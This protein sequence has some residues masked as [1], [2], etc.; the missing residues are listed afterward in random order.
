VLLTFFLVIDRIYN[1]TDLVIT[2]GVPFYLVVQLLAFMLPS[3]LAI[4]LPMAFLSA[5]LLAG[6]R[7]A[8]DLEI[9]AFRAAGV[10][11]LRLFRPVLLASLVIMAATAWFTLV[12]NPLANREFQRQLFRILQAKAAS[13]LQ[14]RI[15]LGTFGDVTIYVEDVSVSQVALR[16]LL[17]SDERDPKMSRII[18]ARE[19]RLRSDE[20]NQRITLSMIDGAV[21]EVDVT[22]GAAQ[23]TTA[24]PLRPAVAPRYRHTRFET[25]DMSLAMS[26]PLIGAAR[27]DKPERDA[28]LGEL[29]QKI[30]E[31]GHQ[32]VNRLPYEIERHKRFALPAAALVFGLIAFPLAIRS[33][34]GGRSIAFIGSL[35]ILVIYYLLITSLEGFAL[36]GRIP[37]AVAIWTPNVLFTGAGFGL[38]VATAREWRWPAVP[39]LWRGLERVRRALPS[40][41]ASRVRVHAAGAGRDSTHIIDRYLVREY[42]AFMG[43]GLAVSAALFVMIDLL[44]TLDRYLR[45]KPPLVFIIEHFVYRLPA[46][47]HLYLPVVMLVATIFLFLTLGRYHELTALKAAGVS[48]YRVSMPIL[49]LGLAIAIGAGVFQE[50]ALP[51]LNE[52]GDE[53]DRVKIRGMA[54]RHLQLRHRLW[55][56]SSDSRFYRVELLHPGTNDMFGVTILELN[57]DFRLTG[58]LDARQAHWTPAGWELRDGAYREIS[59]DGA[60]Q[61]LPFRS[62]AVELSEEM[63]DF[64]RI[65]KPVTAMSF[66][67]LKDYIARLEAAGFQIRKHLVEL[68]A[69]L[70]FPLVNLV[71]VLVAIPLALQSPRGGRL[72]GIGLA[73]G[74]MAGYLVV[75]FVALAFARADLL[76]PLI[77]AWTANIIFMGIGVSLLLRA[78]T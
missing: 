41:A 10:S 33:H 76:P 7:L 5:V 22:P 70:S 38:L 32:R 73:L 4:T 6:G 54:P 65:Q 59:P 24:D 50:L 57:R 40:R 34:R 13:G 12:L 61:T 71:M 28:T 60:V 9:V 26:S 19:G 8:S 43:L 53:V 31:Y 45:L 66:R 14:E 27:N 47:L 72:F 58:R 48:L 35:V 30:A 68:Y 55:L 52:R 63:D 36:R 67:E 49:G 18:T 42:L 2:K 46:A 75:H 11:A 25:Y 78:R 15:F 17:V 21:N 44:Q 64:I 39:L 77:A 56:R 51:V 69:K 23:P 3:F 37:A 20:A 29:N 62:T 1:L 16:G 74:I